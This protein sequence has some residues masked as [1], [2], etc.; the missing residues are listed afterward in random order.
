MT[1]PYPISPDVRAL[2]PGLVAPENTQPASKYRNVKTEAAG[3]RFQSGHEAAV[4][5]GLILAEKQGKVF[6]LRLQVR[7][8][9]PGGVTYVADAVFSEVVGGKLTVIVLD[10]KGVRTEGYKIKRRQFREL[11]G[12]EITEV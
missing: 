7:F 11:Y 6:G 12:L 5:S 8:P 10:A 9:L 3:L 1:F 4:I 2:N